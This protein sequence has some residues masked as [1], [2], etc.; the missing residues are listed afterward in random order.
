MW[1]PIPEFPKRGRRLRVNP[2]CGSPS[3][4]QP[5]TNQG[6]NCLDGPE[7]WVFKFDVRDAD[8]R[9]PIAMEMKLKIAKLI[10]KG[11]CR[12]EIVGAGFVL[13][14]MMFAP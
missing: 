13:A 12:V 10:A 1:E 3:T 6:L 2:E 9:G 4:W 7:N 11:I 8:Y 5:L 14:L